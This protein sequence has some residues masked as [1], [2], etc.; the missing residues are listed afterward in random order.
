[1]YPS[2]PHIL[3]TNI[4]KKIS[5]LNT[6][7]VS[8]TWGHRKTPQSIWVALC[9]WIQVA[10]SYLVTLTQKRK[11]TPA[12]KPRDRGVWMGCQYYFS[13]RFLSFLFLIILFIYLV[14]LDLHCFRGFS[15]VTATWGYSLV[16]GVQASHCCGFSCWGEWSLEHLGASSLGCGLSSC[17]SQAPEHRLSSLGTRA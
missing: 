8:D 2:A 9:F 5:S 4:K 14:A 10:S 16:G 13:L 3:N 6:F 15:L 12:S 7:A 1:M 17:G 11:C